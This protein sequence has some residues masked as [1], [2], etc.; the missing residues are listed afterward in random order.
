MQF[1]T[2]THTATS[3]HSGL[4]PLPALGVAAWRA[5]ANSKSAGDPKPSYASASAIGLAGSGALS[6]PGRPAV[7][8]R[9]VKMLG[10]SLR[11]TD[12]SE[13]PRPAL[14]VRGPETEPTG[15]REGEREINVFP[16]IM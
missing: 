2:R 3:S 8:G 15:H 1:P 12:T 9:R 13:P 4:A 10:D 6:L 14:S 16:C 11:P 5:L 7:P